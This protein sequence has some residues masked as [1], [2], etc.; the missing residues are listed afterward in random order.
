MVFVE[1]LQKMLKLDL[2]LMNKIEGMNK[3]DPCLKEKI[4]IVIGSME[5]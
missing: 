1:I 4:K 2:I 5:V 3:I